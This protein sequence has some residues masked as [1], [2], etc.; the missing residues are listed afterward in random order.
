ML[1]V[2]QI[3]LGNTRNVFIGKIQLS[4]ASQ[5][6]PRS[7]ALKAIRN[8]NPKCLSSITITNLSYSTEFNSS[9]YVTK[10]YKSTDAKNNSSI[11]LVNK[12]DNVFQKKKMISCL[13]MSMHMV[14]AQ[15]S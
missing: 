8:S 11:L 9:N 7:N 4:F 1:K 14:K 12:K 2:G 15:V 5:I 6:L 10:L 3:F 13:R